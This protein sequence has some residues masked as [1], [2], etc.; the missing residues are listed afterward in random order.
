MLSC[1]MHRNPEYYNEIKIEL[2][3]HLTTKHHILF[4]FYHIS[5]I[6]P[7]PHKPGFQPP[8]FLGCTVSIVCAHMC[9]HLRASVSMSVCLCLCMSEGGS[10][11]ML[12]FTSSFVI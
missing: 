5:G 1:L 6:K 2:P 10:L 3:A 7:R 8:Q 9:T 11:R 12:V 4:T